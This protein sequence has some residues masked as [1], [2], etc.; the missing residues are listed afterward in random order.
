V[1]VLNGTAVQLTAA[2]S[3]AE[4]TTP[5]VQQPLALRGRELD[6]E[7]VGATPTVVGTAFGWGG[8][9]FNGAGLPVA[10][11]NTSMPW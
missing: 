9:L 2:A 5:G 3:Y 8:Y 4:R 11:W 1:A 10:P 6:G 7:G